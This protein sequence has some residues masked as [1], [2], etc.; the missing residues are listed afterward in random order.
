MFV[1]FPGRDGD[2]QMAVIGVQRK[3]VACGAGNDHFSQVSNRFGNEAAGHSKS[4]AAIGGN[5]FRAAEKTFFRPQRISNS[6]AIIFLVTIRGFYVFC[7]E[8]PFVENAVTK[9]DGGT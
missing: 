8:K 3:Q 7:G 4:S 2:A 9:S 1:F 6:L 5:K